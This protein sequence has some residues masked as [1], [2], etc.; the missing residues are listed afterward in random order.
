MRHLELRA[1]AP[2]PVQHDGEAAGD[3]HD[4]ALHAASF[5][6]LHA[7]GLEPAFRLRLV[8]HHRRCLEQSGADVPVASSA[9]RPYHVAFSGL[10]AVPE[11]AVAAV[12]DTLHE[13][14]LAVPA[15]G[16]G[17]TFLQAKTANEVMKAQER[18]LRLS[19]LKG[20]ARRLI[21]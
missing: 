21:C 14:G 19:R 4:G 16:G 20:D 5:G 9:D 2:H 17:T 8:E 6:D 13:Q 11:A 10:L 1:V 3:S 15:V 7:P 18:R 12:G